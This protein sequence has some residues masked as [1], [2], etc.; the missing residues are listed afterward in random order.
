MILFFD[1]AEDTNEILS[2]I[3]CFNLNFN[4]SEIPVCTLPMKNEI[5]DI[6]IINKTISFFFNDCKGI[7]NNSIEHIPG[8]TIIS[9]HA[10]DFYVY[11]RKIDDGL[12]Y[13]FEDRHCITTLQQYY[14]NKYSI[15]LNSTQVI[16]VRPLGNF[17]QAIRP[18]VTAQKYSESLYLPIEQCETYPVPTEILF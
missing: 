15:E 13:E 12:Y 17:R 18:R 9:K 11:L 5:L 6:S 1:A 7:S 10:K 14:A 16:E 4:L 3:I 8:S 2:I